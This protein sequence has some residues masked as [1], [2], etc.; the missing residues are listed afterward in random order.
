MH[1]TPKLPP[2]RSNRKALAFS[3]EIHRLRTGGYSF[4][5]IRLALRDVGVDVSRTTVKRE[6][7]R[8]PAM[9]PLAQ[10][11][12]VPQPVASVARASPSARCTVALSAG[13][14]PLAPEGVEK[15]PLGRANAGSRST[16]MARYRQK[17]RQPERLTG[18]SLCHDAATSASIRPQETS[19]RPLGR[20][21]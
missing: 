8:R 21:A 4:E 2:G 11:R 10:P 5:A 18:D 6:A 16:P 12:D 19:D 9:A 20:C 15:Q 1:L 17:Y 7:A 14:S 3:T 13:S